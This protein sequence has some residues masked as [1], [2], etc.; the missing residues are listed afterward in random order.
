MAP[1]R[2]ELENYFKNNRKYFDE[3]AKNYKIT[4]PDYYK[5]NIE[6]F[7]SGFGD[8]Q[9]GRNTKPNRLFAI[10]G[11]AMVMALGIFFLIFSMKQKSLIKQEIT[12][13]EIEIL[14]NE[15]STK[16]DTVNQKIL[17]TEKLLDTMNKVK[18][19]YDFNHGKFLFKV[20]KFEEAEKFLKKVPKDHPEYQQVEYML[21]EIS[22][23]K[24][25]LKNP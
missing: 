22:K 10:T 1:S 14:K 19:N 18:K 4:D 17:E 16:L 15:V 24:S 13:E 9:K 2:E 25:P 5:K 6:P 3:L 23:E 20:R 7:Y 8:L 11:L 12:P 21:L